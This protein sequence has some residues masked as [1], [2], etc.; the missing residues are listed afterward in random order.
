[1]M[2]LFPTFLFSFVF[3]VGLVLVLLSFGF[4]LACDLVSVLASRL[5][6]ILIFGSVVGCSFSLRARFW[7]WLQVLAL[8]LR[9]LV[10]CW[11]PNDF[12]LAYG[13]NFGFG[14]DFL[15]L[16]SGLGFQMILAWLLV[17]ATPLISLSGLA[18]IFWFWFWIPNDFGLAVAL[19]FT[20][21][22][23][24]DFLLASIFEF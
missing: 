23:G 5:A 1:M 24:F 6:F 4:G 3:W 7:F 15:V 19:A 13:F 8:V 12:G 20:L 22:F 17:L 14:R 2:V 9:L 21:G 11:V 18:E 10:W 16:V